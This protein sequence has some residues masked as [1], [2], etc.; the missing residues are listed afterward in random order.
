MDLLGAQSI[1]DVS[2]DTIA[3]S[4]GLLENLSLYN[5]P[6]ITDLSMTALSR[7]SKSSLT[8]LDLAH[9]KV[10]DDGITAIGACCLISSLSLRGL[11]TLTDAAALSIAR[12]FAGL[13]RLNLRG[14]RRLSNVGV[15]AIVT[16]CRLE[17]L[18]LSW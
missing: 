8:A 15:S 5:C 18:D 2:V 17:V 11:R 10:T 13:V 12:S 3:R 9:T 1:S 14:C 6:Q 4:L 7:H 16:K